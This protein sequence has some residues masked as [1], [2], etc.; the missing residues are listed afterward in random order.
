MPVALLGFNSTSEITPLHLPCNQTLASNVL[1]PIRNSGEPEW[2]KG[3]HHGYSMIMM[4]CNHQVPAWKP[5]SR[6][7]IRSFCDPN[8]SKTD[9]K[10]SPK[11]IGFHLFPNTYNWLLLMSFQ[12][13]FRS[14]AVITGNHSP[15]LQKVDQNL[16]PWL[17]HSLAAYNHIV[18]KVVSKKD[19]YQIYIIYNHS[20][21]FLYFFHSFLT[22]SPSC[23]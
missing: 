1:R 7:T 17:S 4:A 5:W 10:I 11:R 23:G 22:A 18:F 14:I 19:I 3:A 21:G 6:I 13:P 20:V 8:Y 12:E 16:V 2:L 9:A 15:N